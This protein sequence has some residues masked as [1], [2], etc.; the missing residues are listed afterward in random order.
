MAITKIG[1][2]HRKYNVIRVSKEN[3][4]DTLVFS[5]SGYEFGGD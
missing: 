3:G 4:R 2:K 1:D 5:I